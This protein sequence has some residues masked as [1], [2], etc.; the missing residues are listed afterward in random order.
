MVFSTLAE[1]N[2]TKH[3]EVINR[4]T[5]EKF[6]EKVYGENAMRIFYGNKTAAS[7]TDKFFTNKWLSNI[8]GA[9]N[10]S[11][12][13]KHKIEEFIKKF[14]VKIADCEK[15]INDYHS[16]NDFFSRKLKLEARTV[17][18]G[19][20]SVICPGDGRLLVFQ[21]IYDTTVSYVKWAPIRLLDLF[22]GN[23]SL[24]ERYKNGSCGILRLCPS[25]YHRF[26]F[27]VGGKAGI[28][29]T[30]PG[31]LHSVNPYALE[32]KIPVYCLNKRTLCEL[33]SDVFGKV[34]LLEVGALFVGTI[35]QNYRPSNLVKKGEEKGYFKF[36]G[37]TCI[38]FF[39]KG[40][41]CFDNDLI[42]NSKLGLE[43]YLHMGSKIASHT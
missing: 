11:S 35:V 1:K 29:K 41:I 21:N 39:E 30:I 7:I 16:F 18:E 33:D 14:D 2:P 3:I 4:V 12:L 37:S 9:F 6:V 32:Q 42:Q 8:Y 28:T 13:S 31:V 5:G 36:G 24:V 20:H 34:L 23:E 27:P 17:D 15:D 26:H 22:N 19:T 38:F 43:T 40:S 10:D 25:D